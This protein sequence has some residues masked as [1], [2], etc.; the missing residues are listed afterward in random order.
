MDRM[1]RTVRTVMKDPAG[2]VHV[3]TEYLL[4]GE[5]VRVSAPYRNG[6]TPVWTRT[7]ADGLGSQTLYPDTSRTVDVVDG[8]KVRERTRDEMD[9]M[10][11]VDTEIRS[12]G[13]KES[14][15]HGVGRYVAWGHAAKGSKA[16]GSADT[17]GGAVGVADSEP[18]RWGGG[19]GDP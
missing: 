16:G 5:T 9:A 2:D 4:D 19:A 7:H 17:I 18:R 6:Q 8:N 13:L 12:R 3:D 15:G 14:A 1:G 10:D 11:A